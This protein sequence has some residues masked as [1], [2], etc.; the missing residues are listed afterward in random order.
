MAPHDAQ[1]TGQGSARSVE[2]VEEQRG[3]SHS[4]EEETC[5]PA[6]TEDGGSSIPGEVHTFPG[7]CQGC[8]SAREEG[9][10]GQGKLS[11]KAAQGPELRAGVFTALVSGSRRGFQSQV[12]SEG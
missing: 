10:G 9:P 7:I 11:A 6:E 5:E 1:G 2:H 12:L 8:K 4:R 3:L